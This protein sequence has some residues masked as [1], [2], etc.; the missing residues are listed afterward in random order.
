[1]TRVAYASG[2]VRRMLAWLVV[3]SFA[4]SFGGGA[5]MPV[6]LQ[7]APVHPS[8]PTGMAKMAIAGQPPGQH[9]DPCRDHPG[10]AACSACPLC[11]SVIVPP[12]VALT[13]S[14]VA[15]S[16]PPLLAPSD[17]SAAGLSPGRLD[18]PPRS[19]G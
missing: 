6:A 9:G 5:L 17:R 13:D 18:R 7:A 14:L 3:V 11:S 8:A 2:M 15:A 10:K 4:V 16:L 12:Q 1:M 19:N